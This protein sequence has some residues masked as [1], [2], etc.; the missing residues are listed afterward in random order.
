M[1]I[2]VIATILVQ[3]RKNSEFE[4]SADCLAANAKPA[5]QINLLNAV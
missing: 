5:P 1:A 2:G 4:H 3:K